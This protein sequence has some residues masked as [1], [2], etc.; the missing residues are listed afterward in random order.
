M[1]KMDMFWDMNPLFHAPRLGPI[2]GRLSIHPPRRLRLSVRARRPSGTPAGA[3]QARFLAEM[4]G[5]A[6]FDAACLAAGLN[7]SDVLLARARN[8]RFAEA[9]DQ[10]AEVQRAAMEAMLLDRGAAVLAA[11]APAVPGKESAARLD[12]ATV[13]LLQWILGPARAPRTVRNVEPKQAGRS[14]ETGAAADEAANEAE[15]QKV[16]AA[17]LAQLAAVEAAMLGV[18]AAD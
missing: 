17:A 10:V 2:G 16:L 3:A 7:R 18:E 6:G 11:P 14:V 9:W 1:T 13:A 8:A 4:A 15:A 12:K 5:G